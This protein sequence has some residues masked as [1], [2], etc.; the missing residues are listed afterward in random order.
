MLLAGGVVLGLNVVVV[1]AVVVSDV[2][3]VGGECDVREDSVTGLL[4][5]LL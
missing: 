1:V 3:V 4:R 5:L 2:V